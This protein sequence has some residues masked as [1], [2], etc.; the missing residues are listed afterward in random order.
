MGELHIDARK[1]LTM[2]KEEWQHCTDCALGARR[3][4]VGGR[5][6]FGEG[7]PR[8][9]MFIADGP[10]E[11]EEFR[12]E[13]FAGAAGRLLHGIMNKYNCPEYYTTYLVACRSCEIK[14]H[15]ETSLPITRNGEAQFQDIVPLPVQSAACRN[16]LL[17]EIYLVDPIIIVTLGAPASEAVLG[18]PVTITKERGRAQHISIPGA[19]SRPVLTDTKKAW[20]RK[21]HGNISWPVE[22]NEVRYLVIPT[23]NPSFVLRKSAD[24]TE[25]GPFKHLQTDLRSIVGIY[26]RYL[27]EVYNKEPRFNLDADFK[28]M[29]LDEDD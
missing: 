3:T 7:V 14:L 15:K 20:R 8:A 5:F 23:L 11:I 18:K 2:L 17:E 22:P 10:D 9:I 24:K 25:R 19:L 6:V 29:E 1:T 12:G 21:L 13:P 27:V 26:E 4:R 16:R 28:D